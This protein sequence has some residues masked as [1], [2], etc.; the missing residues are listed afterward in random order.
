MSKLVSLDTRV[1][2]DVSNVSSFDDL[3][4]RSGFNFDIERV[5]CHTPEGNVLKN[6]YIIRR[7][8]NKRVLSVVRGRYTPVN[9]RKMFEPFHNMVEKYGATYETA[10]VIGG[11]KKCWIS[12]N[13]PNTFEVKGRDGDVIQR[14]IL[15]LVAHDS[16][17]RN[18][19]FSLAHRIVCN[20]QLRLINNAANASEYKVSHTKNWEAQWELAQGGFDRAIESHQEFENI[21]NNLASKE[22]TVP[23]V[24]GFTMELFPERP[25]T[26]EE[27]KTKKERRPT[28]RLNNRR[29]QV[30]DLF[31]NGQGNMGRNRW[32]ALNA[33][34]EYMD[35][36]NQINK[37]DHKKNGYRNAER[38]FVSN[39]L[40]GP[41]DIVK[42]KALQLLLTHHNFNKIKEFS[43]N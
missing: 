31:L 28:S 10:G 1:G 42:Q 20:N 30:V 11:G 4:D 14:R 3:M 21:I 41:G 23:E 15:A 40:A 24:R 29:E 9:T 12:A 39:V 25:L 32:D 38:R 22:L 16:T 17:S 36:H 43:N 2:T 26:E 27:I 35:H 7:E 33:V 6:Q 13:L 18:A 19:Y 34:T 37:L 5:P 8:D